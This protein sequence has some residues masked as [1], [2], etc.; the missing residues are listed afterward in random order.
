MAT[1]RAVEKLNELRESKR[2]VEA[3]A[4]RL[5]ATLASAIQL[6]DSVVADVDVAIKNEV[7]VE[8]AQA[9]QTTCQLAQPPVK[10]VVLKKGAVAL[11]TTDVNEETGEVTLTAALAAGDTV[12]ANYV[13][14]GLKAELQELLLSL[15]RMPLARIGAFGAT[16]TKY[17]NASTWLMANLT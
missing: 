9:G 14:V 8:A 7:V 17:V 15:P 3:E 4:G 12:T 5:A 6:A 2:R 16:R 1:P 10:N 11:P 13:H